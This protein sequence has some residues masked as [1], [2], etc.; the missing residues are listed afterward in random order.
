MKRLPLFL[1][2]LFVGCATQQRI[3]EPNTLRVSPENPRYFT[4]N[5]GKA[6]L[7]TGSHV[8]NNLVDIS[9]Q[10]P[11]K[12][13]DFE[14]HIAWLES[15]NHNFVRLWAWELVT[16]DTVKNEKDSR[17]GHFVAPHPF[18]RTGPGLALDG[19]PKF[20]VWKINPDYLERLRQRVQ[21]AQNHG[22]YVAVMLFEGWGL[23]FEPHGIRSHPFH[24]DNNIN[25]INGDPDGDGMGLEIHEGVIPEITE[26]QR[27]YVRRVIDTINDFDN[28]LFEISNENH[29]ASTPWQFAMIRFIREYESTKP[30]QHP[31]GMTFQYKGGSNKT[32]LDSPADWISPNGEGDYRDNPPE[33]D[34]TKVILSDTD[35]LWGIGGYPKWVWKSFLRGLNPIY[36]DPIDGSVIS[37]N[38]VPE[39]SES[40]RVAMGY[41]RAWS[42]RINLVAMEPENELSSTG[43]CLADPGQEYLVYAGDEDLEVTVHLLPGEYHMLWFDTETG[44]ETDSKLLVS[45]GINNRLSKPFSAPSLLHLKSTR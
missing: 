22:V 33:A 24:K 5:S 6:I 41:A 31:I 19:K 9:P 38:Y 11:P 21:T 1:L 18:P 15:H 12:P 29:P 17:K 10:D 43:Y 27:N 4:D 42:E 16:W 7:L 37:H 32:L 2:L 39:L 13:L 8:W 3:P 40:I 35:H 34:G 20:D 30:K 36:M 26:I 44:E 25:G 14:E 45:G 28:V 23:Q